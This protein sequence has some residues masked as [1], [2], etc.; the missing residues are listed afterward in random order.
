VVINPGTSLEVLSE[1]IEAVEVV[2][3]MTVDPGF[4]GQAFIPQMVDKVGRMAAMLTKRK[5][6]CEL[7]VDG[8]VDA[9]TAPALV[10]AGANVLVAGSAIFGHPHGPAEGLQVLAAAASG[11]GR[12]RGL[13]PRAFGPSQTGEPT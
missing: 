7:A 5:P 1:V 8:G 13:G 4:G 6:Q 11:Q 2:L 9:E 10:A 12:P 3:V